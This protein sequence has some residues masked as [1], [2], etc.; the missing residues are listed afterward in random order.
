MDA[1]KLAEIL[2]SSGMDAHT[3]HISKGFTDWDQYRQKIAAAI[4]DRCEVREK[5]DD[6]LYVAIATGVSRETI[7]SGRDLEYVTRAARDYAK[8]YPGNEVTIFRAV[9]SHTY[10]K[11]PWQ[12]RKF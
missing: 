5:D 1:E 7:A 4:L 11:N 6:S 8:S 3:R 2:H 12:V 10:T 9:E